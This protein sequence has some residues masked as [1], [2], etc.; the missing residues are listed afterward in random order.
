MFEEIYKAYEECRLNC[1]LAMKQNT[2]KIFINNVFSF[3]WEMQPYFE[4]AEIFQYRIHVLT[5][6]NRHGSENSHGITKE[7][8]LKM[9]EKFKVKLF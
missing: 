9:A 7:Q 2:E 1:E 6:E 5:V 8:I 3:E 4:L